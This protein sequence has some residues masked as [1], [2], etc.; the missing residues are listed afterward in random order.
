MCEQDNY[1]KLCLKVNVEVRSCCL[2]C[3][4]NICNRL[5]KEANPL[6][7]TLT[8]IVIFTNDEYRVKQSRCYPPAIQEGIASSLSKVVLNSFVVSFA[9]LLFSSIFCPMVVFII[10]VHNIFL[11]YVLALIS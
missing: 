2:L 5:L 8:K 3:L 7:N 6:Y 9:R 10:E 1:L 11:N 4:K